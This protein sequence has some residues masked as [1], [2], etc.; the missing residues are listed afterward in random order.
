MKVV[1]FAGAL[2]V[3]IG[4]EAE[5]L[6]KPMVEIDRINKQGRIKFTF[7]QAICLSL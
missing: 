6:R 2:R 1:V 4:A 5:T 7:N 3:S